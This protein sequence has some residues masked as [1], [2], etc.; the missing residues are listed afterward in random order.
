MKKNYKFPVVLVALV[1]SCF[2]T[3]TKLNAQNIG[4][5]STGAAPAA[6]AGLDVDFTNKGLLIPRVALTAKNAAGPIAAPATSLLVYNTATAGV[7]PNNVFPGYY[8]WDGAAWVAIGGSGGK[9]WGVLGNAGTV[10]GTNFLGTTDAQGVDFRTGNTTR[11]R[12]PNADQ[13]HANANGTAALPFYSWASDPDVGM[14]RVNT[15]T[16]GFS[17]TGTERLII[18][19]SGQ[20]GVNTPAPVAGDLLSSNGVAGNEWAINGYNNQAIGSGVYATNTNAANSYSAVEGVKTGSGTGAGVYGIQSATAVPA[21]GTSGVIGEFNGTAN[22]GIRVGV[23]GISSRG[24]GNR[25]I[26]VIGEYN[27]AGWGLGMCGL[28]FGGGIPAGNNDIA[29][30]GWRANNANFSGYFNGNHVI[31]NGTKSASVATSKGNQLLYVMESPE[32]WF[33]DIGRGKLINGSVEIKL[34]ELFLETVFIDESHPISVFIQ[35]EGESNGLYVLI[36]KDGFVVKEKNGG[37]ANISFSYRVLAKRVHFQDHRFGND[38]VWGPGDTRQ[39]SQYA[40]P[41]AIDYNDNI[42]LQE[43]KRRNYKRPPMPEGFVFGE[44]LIL[45]KTKQNYLESKG[46]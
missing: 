19:A 31:A 3:T 14:Y 25:Q 20:V 32:V 23:R 13:I 28:S 12:I 36:G 41:P 30:V 4:I 33:E 5:N 40:V 7:S 39:Y 26:G 38:P 18:N 16:L 44:D 6:S 27:G 43:E 45:P 9:D 29:I 8:Y 42:Q 10:F 2:L 24:A 15:N 46:E 35:E 17:T 1:A 22:S 34:D 37:T 11:L 21:G